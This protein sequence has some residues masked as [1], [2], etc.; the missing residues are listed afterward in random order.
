MPDAL[1]AVLASGE[2]TTTEALMRACLD[3]EIGCQVGLV[4]SSRESAGVLRRVA[5]VDREYSSSTATACIGR[6]SHPA[7][8]GKQLRPGD[9]T[10]A[11]AAAIG[12]LLVDGG[13]EL[14]VLMGYLK[15]VA[16]GL[17]DTFGWRRGFTSPYQARMLNIHPG[18]LPE[19]KGLYGIEVQRVV[20]ES[21]L[22]Y[23]AHVVH[24][25]AE[26]YDDGPVVF[27]HR[28]KVLA[29][30]TPATLSERVKLLQRTEIPHD[31]G[32]FAREQR[33]YAKSASAGA[34]HEGLI[35]QRIGAG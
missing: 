6:R 4:I 26:D 12:Q 11:E 33:R 17:V 29:T 23:A 14:V 27:E 32:V 15:R 2:G 19:T 18:P 35:P 25:V 24:V 7:S 21:S 1:V 10:T 22:G 34:G 5:A 3:G 31:I 30:D 8:D 13:F 9:Q 28:T 16:A 20:L